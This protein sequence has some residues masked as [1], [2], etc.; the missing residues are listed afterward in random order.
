MST[1]L[2]S[3]TKIRYFNCP[4]CHRWVSSTYTEVFR[5]DAKLRTRPQE[6]PGKSAFA[7]VK[8]RL[9]SWLAAAEDQDPYR[10]LG[11]SPSDSLDQI[12]E[13]YR[14][15][16][17]ANHPDRGGHPDRMRQI[18]EA[19]EKIHLHRERREESPLELLPSGV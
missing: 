10:A 13:K 3:G 1:H 14:E 5:A 15:L 16:A 12:R 9:E 8:S 6:R 2:G 11:V 19:Y 18:N 4:C 17:I 7:E